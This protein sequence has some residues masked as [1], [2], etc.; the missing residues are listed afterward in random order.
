MNEVNKTPTQP[1]VARE[2]EAVRNRGRCVAIKRNEI[3]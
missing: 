3:E 2:A 1:H